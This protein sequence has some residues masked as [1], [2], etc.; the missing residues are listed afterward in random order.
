MK[1]LVKITVKELED[2]R[3]M[4]RE[5]EKLKKALRVTYKIVRIPIDVSL[6]DREQIEYKEAV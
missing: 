1:H 4:Q 2:L 3:K 5:F 6:D